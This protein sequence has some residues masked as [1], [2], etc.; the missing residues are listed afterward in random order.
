LKQA[1]IKVGLLFFFSFLH[2]LLYMAEEFFQVSWEQLIVIPSF[3][4]PTV[5]SLLAVLGPTA[6][7]LV[8]SGPKPRRSGALESLSLSCALLL[9]L[10][11]CRRRVTS[12]FFVT[13]LHT[14]YYLPPLSKKGTEAIHVAVHHLPI[15]TLF[16]KRR[17]IIFSMEL[18]T[19]LKDS[20][21][22]MP[23]C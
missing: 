14:E 20:R 7:M 3:V 13:E 19:D 6:M 8:E 5:G 11:L 2:V 16:A 10:A 18:V 9:F 23:V 21:A 4:G 22:P 1:S 12:D 15:S 17:K